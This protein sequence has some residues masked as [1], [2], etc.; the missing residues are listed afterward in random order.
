M[1]VCMYCQDEGGTFLEDTLYRNLVLFGA[2]MVAQ[3]CN[4]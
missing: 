1:Y 4:M 2:D 3:V